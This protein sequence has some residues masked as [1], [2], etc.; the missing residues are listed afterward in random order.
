MVN[1]ESLINDASGL[2]GFKYAI[3]ATVYG[4]FSLKSA[5]GDFFYISIVGAIIGVVTMLVISLVRKWLYKNGL[6]N[7]VFNVVLQ[8][9]SP[10]V[11][12]LLS[13][14]VFPCFGGNCGGHSRNRLPCE[15]H[16]NAIII[17]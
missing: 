3:A 15:Q 17:S 6:T 14:D 10:F 4:A 5:V 7:L 1:G 13:E 8:I 9:V 16:I 11:I 12:Y 2:I